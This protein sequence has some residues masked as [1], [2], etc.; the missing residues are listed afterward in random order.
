MQGEDNIKPVRHILPK[1]RVWS[2]LST[3]A[4]MMAP[5]PVQTGFR[6]S[7]WEKTHESREHLNTGWAV[8]PSFH[9][10]TEEL[11]CFLG[12]AALINIARRCH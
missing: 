5:A 1:R 4:A 10:A 3:L 7:P 9:S 11:K 12:R 2:E 6:G 8:E